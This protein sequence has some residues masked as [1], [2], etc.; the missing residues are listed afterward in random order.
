MSPTTKNQ[1]NT[2]HTPSHPFTPLLTA[3]HRYT[4]T[5]THYHPHSLPTRTL[6][7]LHSTP[8]P[9]CANSTLQNVKCNPLSHNSLRKVRAPLWR[10]ALLVNRCFTICYILRYPRIRKKLPEAIFSKSDSEYPLARSSSKS[11]G[12][13]EISSIPEG[14]TAIPS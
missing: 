13:I 11:F 2:L 12:I 14:V 8:T 7:Q 1:H 10:H 6:H 4:Y 5:Y 9:L 3:T